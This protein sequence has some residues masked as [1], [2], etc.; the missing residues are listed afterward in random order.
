MFPQVARPVYA[1]SL[2]RPRRPA[3]WNSGA[4]SAH[5]DLRG[6]ADKPV[7]TER[8][9]TNL[10]GTGDADLFPPAVFVRLLAAIRLVYMG[11]E[12]GF[13]FHANNIVAKYRG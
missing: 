9:K 7:A 11:R 10:F 12:D 2:T 5:P 4:L 1:V 13:F 3:S 8:M 6:F